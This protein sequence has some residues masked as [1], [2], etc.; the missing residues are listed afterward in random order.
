M[1]FILFQPENICIS[2]VSPQQ[3]HRIVFNWA[4][5]KASRQPC[6]EESELLSEINWKFSKMTFWKCRCLLSLLF[7]IM[8]WCLSVSSTVTS[9]SLCLCL[10][11][12]FLNLLSYSTTPSLSQLEQ[13]GVTVRRGVVQVEKDLWLW[14]QQWVQIEYST[15]GF[16][17]LQNDM[18]EVQLKKN[19]LC[20]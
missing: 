2:G 9:P 16:K 15:N 7:I 14:W 19:W 6:V 11:F 18:N 5:N 10:Y 8:G 20:W 4:E 12:K 3:Q 17:V 1:H 13:A